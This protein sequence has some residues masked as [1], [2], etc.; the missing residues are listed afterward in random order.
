[1]SPLCS[2]EAS[3]HGRVSLRNR[4]AGHLEEIGDAAT[5]ARQDIFARDLLVG[6][7]HVGF[8]SGTVD[9]HIAL[10]AILVFS[11]RKTIESIE[12]HLRIGGLADSGSVDNVTGRKMPP[13]PYQS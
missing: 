4:L 3:R 10:F 12:D 13:A 6:A 5:K 1:V 11:P 9:G 7:Q 8:A 2:P